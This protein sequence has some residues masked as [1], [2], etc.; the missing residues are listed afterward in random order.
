MCI[1]VYIY[2]IFC[3]GNIHISFLKLCSLTDKSTKYQN[4]L[5]VKV[6]YVDDATHSHIC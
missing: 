6:L 2:A 5:H 4:I 3:Y 1:Y